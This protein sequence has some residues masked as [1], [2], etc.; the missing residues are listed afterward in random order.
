MDVLN[1]LARFAVGHVLSCAQ[2]EG[3]IEEVGFGGVALRLDLQIV[4]AHDGYDLLHD[5]VHLLGRQVAGIYI[6]YI[7]GIFLIVKP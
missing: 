2:V 6:L 4:G 7:D 3:N 5:L 1:H